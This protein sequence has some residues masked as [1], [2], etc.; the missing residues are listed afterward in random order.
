MAKALWLDRLGITASLGCAVHCILT[1]LLF[2]LAPAVFQGAHF[3]KPL[4][5]L[6]HEWIHVGM[7]LLVFPVAV[8]ALWNGYRTHRNKSGLLLG[9]VGLSL[10]I[11]GLLLHGET[12]EIVLTLLGGII[13]AAAH[14][15]NLRYCQHSHEH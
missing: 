5:F 1:A 13:L 15:V 8:L 7:A 10:L 9:G 3:Y 11:S 2:V 4:N 12:M 14:L 6:T